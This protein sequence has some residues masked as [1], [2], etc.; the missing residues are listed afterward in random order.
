MGQLDG[1]LQFL[2]D[3][4][5]GLLHL[6]LRDNETV[7]VDV[8]ELQFVAFHGIVAAF[9]DISQYRGH[10]L[11]QFGDIEMRTLHNLCPLASFW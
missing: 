9:P 10:G 2:A 5:L 1:G 11:V 8:V 7:E 3:E 4:F 6:F